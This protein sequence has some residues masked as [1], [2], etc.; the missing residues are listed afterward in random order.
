MPIEFHCTSCGRR[1]RTGDDTAGKRAKCPQCGTV[2]TIPAAPASS[3]GDAPPPMPPSAPREPVNPF[4]S[5]QTSTMAAPSP[6]E[7][8]PFDIQ[9]GTL[10]FGDIFSRTWTIFKS[11]L[12]MCVLVVLVFVLVLI[13]FRVGFFIFMMIAT[14]ITGSEAV[15]VLVN[16]LGVIVTSIV[17][18]YLQMGLMRIFLKIARGQDFSVGELFSGGPLF[19]P[20]LGASILVGL[21]VAAGTICCIVPGVIVALMFSQVQY[22]VLDRQVPV[23]DSFGVSRKLMVGN[24]VTLFV[25]GLVATVLVWIVTLCTCGIGALAALPWFQ[26][27]MAVVYLTLIGEPTVRLQPTDQPL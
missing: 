20:F 18:I 2:V 10:D 4:Q 23:F 21:A 25:I 17:Q 24:K 1:L 12:G 6:A 22:L 27:M 14:A 3:P 15:G 26:L 11:Q 8:N 19:L 7:G 16:V 9:P 5:P 13:G